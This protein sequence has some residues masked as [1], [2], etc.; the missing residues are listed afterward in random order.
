MR[1]DRGDGGHVAPSRSLC[2]GEVISRKQRVRPML[3]YKKMN[4]FAP[5]WAYILVIGVWVFL[6]FTMDHIDTGMA[7]LRGALGLRG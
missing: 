2:R 6:S 1:P 4:H 7:G 5:V 3:F